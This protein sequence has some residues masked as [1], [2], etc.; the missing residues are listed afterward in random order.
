MRARAFGVEAD[1]PIEDSWRE[2]VGH[3]VFGLAMI[4]AMRRDQT[5]E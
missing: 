5:R 4:V 3:A 2:M 1:D